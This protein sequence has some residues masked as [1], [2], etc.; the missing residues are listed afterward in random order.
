MIEATDLGGKRRKMEERKENEEY[1]C[2][3]YQEAQ[4]KLMSFLDLK[5]PPVAVRLIMHKEPIPEG[6]KELEK[7]MFYCAMVKYA[8]LGNVFYAREAMH[9]CKRGAF[10]LGL[11]EIPEDE[12][13]GEFYVNKASC[14]SRRA[15]WRF[16]DASLNLK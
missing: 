5:Y 14:S 9:E 1:E 3:D 13:S 8:M 7:S 15:A 6:V 16:V 10:A 4:E 12:E 2:R 11:C